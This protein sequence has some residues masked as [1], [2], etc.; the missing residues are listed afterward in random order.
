MHAYAVQDARGQLKLDAMEN[1]FSLPEPLQAAGAAA[2][3]W[4]SIA[5]RCASV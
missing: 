5:T 1:P 2:G 3:P 4:P